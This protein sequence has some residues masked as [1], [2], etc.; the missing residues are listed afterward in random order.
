MWIKDR[1]QRIMMLLQA[2]HRISTDTLAGEF[3]VSRETVRRD[4]LEL[5]AEGHVKRVHGG[6][7]L[8][9]PA[10]EE[11]FQERM[12]LHLNEKK[13]I[14]RQAIKLLKPGQCVMIDAG[15][16]TS[17]FARELGKVPN[18]LVV[19]NS[20]DIITTLRQSEHSV[21]VLLM[22]GR[23]V[24][25]VPATYGEFA[26]ADI[27][28]FNAD[29]AVISPVA[30]HSE[31]GA[32]N[33][34]VHEAET[35]RAMIAQSHKVIMLADHTKLETTSRVQFCTPNEVDVMVT[36]IGAEQKD[37]DAL[38]DQGLKEIIIAP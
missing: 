9:H 16:T 12:S 22:G 1:H 14:S 28:R 13:A 26:L 24:S 7:V 15:T 21:E 30:F 38:R 34:D 5:E 8:P 25:D 35:A 29:V 10:P 33:Y 6:A 32:T 23:M 2:H 17:V 27:A 37:L 19:T 4:L 11:P 20:I 18:L 3:G 36:S 31:H